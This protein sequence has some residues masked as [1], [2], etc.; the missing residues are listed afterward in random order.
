[1]NLIWLFF[2]LALV[3]FVFAKIEPLLVV[4]ALAPLGLF[5]THKTPL[6]ICLRWFGM[7]VANLCRS[8]LVH[9]RSAADRQVQRA[10]HG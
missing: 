1:M 7:A 3:G 9:S 2:T 10:A 6:F 5:K 4:P 8:G